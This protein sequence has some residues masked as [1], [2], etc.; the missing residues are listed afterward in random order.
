L[1][2]YDLNFSDPADGKY[3]AVT[4]QFSGQVFH[5]GQ[6]PVLSQEPHVRNFGNRF[7]GARIVAR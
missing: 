6:D 7:E 2:V 3:Q 1:I 4:G 5:A